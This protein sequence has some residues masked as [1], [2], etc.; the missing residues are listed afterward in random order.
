MFQHLAGRWLQDES[1]TAGFGVVVVVDVV[2][3]VV[4]FLPKYGINSL[5]GL[6]WVMNKQD[7][8]IGQFTAPAFQLT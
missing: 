2:V 7:L 8:H 5:L 1:K 3:V 6:P 4:Y